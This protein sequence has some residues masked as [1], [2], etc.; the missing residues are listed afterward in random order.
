MK[1][2][3]IILIF[4]V[5]FTGCSRKNAFYEFKMSKAQELSISSIQSSKILSK[6]GKVNGLFSA[7]YLNE[8]YPEIYNE[9]EY[10]FVFFFTKDAKEL[11]DQ[12]N[13]IDG[14]LKLTLNSQLPDKI[15]KLPS[16]NNFSHLIDTKNNWNGYYLVTFKKADSI[17]LVLQNDTLSSSVLK[18]KKY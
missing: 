1:V 15:E 8:V 12:S 2:F 17:S 6:D 9:E 5:F 11:Y 16:D 13:P 4:S 10:F 3:F 18:Y 14:N 7:I